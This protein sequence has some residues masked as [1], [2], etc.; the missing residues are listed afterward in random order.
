MAKITS[1][2]KHGLKGFNWQKNFPYLLLYMKP[3]TININIFGITDAFT[4]RSNPL[5][6]Y[7]K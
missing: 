1:D 7:K 4:L 6:E 3:E 2:I 5:S